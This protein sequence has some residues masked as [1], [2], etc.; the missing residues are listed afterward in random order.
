MHWGGSSRSRTFSVLRSGCARTNAI[1]FSVSF[2]NVIL[3]RF[4]L[5]CYL[6]QDFIYKLYFVRDVSDICYFVYKLY[7]SRTRILL[8][9]TYVL[10]VI[11]SIRWAQIMC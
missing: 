3:I 5:T 4:F 7:L 8:V 10:Y 2:C 6:V 1:L 9:D 11:I